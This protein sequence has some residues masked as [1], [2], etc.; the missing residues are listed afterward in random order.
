M[1]S[2]IIFGILILVAGTGFGTYLMYVG[3]GKSSAVS[4]KELIDK[5]EET[6][7]EIAEAK[8]STNPD[9]QK[10]EMI[11]N[12]FNSWANDFVK[13]KDIK[14]L[15][16]EKESIDTKGSR[17]ALSNIWKPRLDT[18]FL[19]IRN[20]IDA[21]NKQTGDSISYEIEKL[22]ENIFDPSAE[23]YTAKVI[24]SPDVVWVMTVTP[25]LP[26]ADDQMPIVTISI[27]GQEDRDAYDRFII[28]IIDS[29]NSDLIQESRVQIVKI[30]N[31]RFN[32]K[33]I[34]QIYEIQ[35]GTFRA[36]AKDLMENQ[37]LQ[38]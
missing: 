19:S 10:I 18:F 31:N 26:L 8:N 37:L 12:E 36:L 35:D 2:Y 22:P 13:N 27:S 23:V 33:S 7:Q 14:R 4:Q 15:E 17:I 1:N 9:K 34:P 30:K 5:I 32:M 6:R 25:A 11:E 21:Y 28:A 16:L 24:F 20:I 3:S 38:L 29:A